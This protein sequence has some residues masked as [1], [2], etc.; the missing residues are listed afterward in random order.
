MNPR[1]VPT[2]KRGTVR[3]KFGSKQKDRN[4]RDPVKLVEQETQ[5]ANRTI[6]VPS[7]RR[8]VVR[9]RPCVK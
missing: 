3:T 8:K 1:I 2:T 5:E 7:E 6:A 9:S 4:K